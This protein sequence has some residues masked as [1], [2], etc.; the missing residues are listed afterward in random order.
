MKLLLAL[1]VL[2]TA[3]TV[4]AMSDSIV[5][6]CL[7]TQDPRSCITSFRS[8]ER[9]SQR[10]MQQRQLDAQLEQ[11]RIQAN[12][13]ALFG[14][15]EALIN[16]MN[17]GFQNMQQPTYTLPPVQPYQPL[18]PVTPPIRCYSSNPGAMQT[19]TCC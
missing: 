2:L 16:G 4:F 7:T 8:E 1:V 15:G 10:D 17:Q 14:S 18:H 11:T 3:S 5:D 13:I 19:T 9:I 6:Y 12:G